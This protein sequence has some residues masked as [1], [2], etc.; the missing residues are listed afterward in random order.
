MTTAQISAI[1]ADGHIR[2]RMED[3]RRY[4]ESPWDQRKTA[5]H[6]GDEPWD[7]TLSGTIKPPYDY[8]PGLRPEEQVSI[9]LKAMDDHNIE[10]AVLFCTGS[11]SSM[12]MRDL[13]FTVA[14]ARAANKLFATEFMNSRLKPVGVLPMR[15]PKQAV[16]ELKRGVEE[17]GLIGFELTTNGIPVAL[18]D[19]FYDEVYREAE[20]LG[21]VICVHGTR[22]WGHEF[23]ADRLRSFAEVHAFTFPAG[24]LLQFT[25]MMCQG[26]PER[27]PELHLAF[28][29]VGA[30][31]LPY[32]L[33]RLDEHWEKRGAAEMKHVSRKPSDVFR[34]SNI[35]VSI[36]SGETLLPQTIEYVGADHLFYATDI[37]HWD[38][39]FPANLTRLRQSDKI[40]DATKRK[41]L[42]DNAK[43]F[44][45]L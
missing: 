5:L 9:W 8:R 29:E 40:D 36:E 41:I 27:F 16:R 2:E 19:P 25:S 34:N 39:E 11:H 26:I 44:Y 23:G 6:P 1:D 37:P 42:H 18:G 21:A 7:S 35:R 38:C 24:I 32:Y 4:L 20:K 30:T 43:A 28:L 33:D 10:T 17:L 45:R 3:V 22:H 12:K 14:V 15:D 31:W 13:D